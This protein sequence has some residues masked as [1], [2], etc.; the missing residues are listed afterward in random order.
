MTENGEEKKF[1]IKHVFEDVLE[2][3]VGKIYFANEE[4]H[5]GLF[6]KLRNSWKSAPRLADFIHLEFRESEDIV[7]SEWSMEFEVDSNLLKESLTKIRSHSISGKSEAVIDLVK[8]DYYDIQKYLVN[9]NLEAE[10]HVTIKKMNGFKCPKLRIF[11]DDVATKFSDICLMA[12]N[13]KFYVLKLFMAS[14]STYFESLFLGK[15]EE[16]Q[17]SE[18]ELKDINP[19]EFQKF[20]EVLYG[21]SAIN[22]YTVKGILKLADMYDAKIAIKRCEEFLLEKSKNS[23]KIKFTLAVRYKLDALKK[24]CL[25]E[26]K[27][28]AEI[29]E[30]VPEKADD[31]DPFVWKELFLKAY[32]SQ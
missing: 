9:E 3:T 4:K 30:L 25:S 21:E 15:F 26:L 14:H 18:I 16:S 7:G 19:D 24:K 20:L 12:G 32:S 6:W 27:T 28:T 22:E 13:Q 10:F 31:F 1:V 29:R 23:M 8:I 17:K 5:F 11:D 2:Q